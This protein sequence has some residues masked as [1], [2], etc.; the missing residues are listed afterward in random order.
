M[1]SQPSD[2]L[3]AVDALLAAVEAGHLLPAPAERI[4]LREAAGLTQAA[5]AQALGVRIPSIQAWEDGRAEPKPERLQAYRRLLD[6][7]AQRYP[8]PVTPEP[9]APAAAPSHQAVAEA[10]V[11]PASTSR[12]AVAKKAATTSADPRFPHGPLAVLDGDGSAYGVDG[13][14]LDCPA[15]TVIELVEWTLKESGLGAAR[16][17]RNGKDSDPLI[18]L[19]ASAAVKLGLPERLE[20]P[21]E[22]RSLR[23]ADDHPVVKQIGKA[24]WQLTQRGFGPWARVYR[25]A[26]GRSRQ[27]VQL[28]VLSWDALE[29][30]SWPGVADMAPADIANVLGTYAQRVITPRGSTAVSG[31]ELMT[32]LRPPTRAVQENGTGAWVSGYNPGSLGSEP[33]DPAPPEAI[34]EHPVVVRSGWKGVS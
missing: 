31:L 28:A 16:L 33:V 10:E 7:L 27:C 32:A 34:A 15:D 14:V 3:A 12:R 17:N 25:K 9:A 30:R 5:V 29:T 20:G 24:K 18:V 21:E 4:R 23:L 8:A 13:I 1:S 2:P 6:G 22:R 19:T 11:R 26:D